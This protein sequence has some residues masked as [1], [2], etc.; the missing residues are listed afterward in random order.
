MRVIRE[1]PAER[2]IDDDPFIRLIRRERVRLIVGPKQVLPG[3]IHKNDPPFI[4][5]QHLI[6]DKQHLEQRFPG[7]IAR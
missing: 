7:E 2:R 5:R 3:V 4:D 6:P 1:H